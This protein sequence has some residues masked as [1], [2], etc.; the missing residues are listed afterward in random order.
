MV[1]YQVCGIGGAYAVIHG[2][3]L[4]F[5]QRLPYA[6]R[7]GFSCNDVLLSACASD[8]Q[9]LM[10]QIQ[11]IIVDIVSGVIIIEHLLLRIGNLVGIQRGVLLYNSCKT[12]VI[13]GLNTEIGKLHEIGIQIFQFQIQNFFGGIQLIFYGKIPC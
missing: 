8:G 7:R 13:V 4:A 3:C 2:T 11:L 9:I 6:F 10:E 12:G 1:V 5:R